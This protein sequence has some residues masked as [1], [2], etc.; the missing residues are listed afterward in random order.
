LSPFGGDGRVYL[1]FVYDGIGRQFSPSVTQG[2][3]LDSKEFI[4]KIRYRVTKK[5][6]EEKQNSDASYDGIKDSVCRYLDVEPDDILKTRRKQP[7]IQKSRKVLM[8]LARQYT[9][10]TLSEIGQKLGGVSPHLVSNAFRQ[11]HSDKNLRDL[12]VTIFSQM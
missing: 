11:L 2:L 12:V 9:P 7:Y 4:D 5:G 10:M 3:Y 1:K 8:Y 6:V